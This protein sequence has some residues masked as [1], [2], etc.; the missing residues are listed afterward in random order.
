MAAPAGR[1]RQVFE[2]W[3]GDVTRC[4]LLNEFIDAHFLDVFVVCM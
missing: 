1:T 4:G 3:Q 2:T